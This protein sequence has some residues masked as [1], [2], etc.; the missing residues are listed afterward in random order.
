MLD[1]DKLR[2][3][4]EKPFLDIIDGLE[5][6][7]YNPDGYYISDIIYYKENSKNW[8]FIQNMNYIDCNYEKVW[9]I[10]SYNN[11]FNVS[12]TQDILSKLIKKYLKQY[13][14]TPVVI[15]NNKLLMKE[16]NKKYFV[17]NTKFKIKSFLK[18]LFI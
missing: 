6:I 9:K 7:K 10:I 8:Y 2:Y 15:K 14:L 4:W 12:A 17:I 18:N 3:I 1:I 16:L 11:Y 13:N 5:Q